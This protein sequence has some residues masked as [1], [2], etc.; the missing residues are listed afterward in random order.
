MILNSICSKCFQ[1]VSEVEKHVLV[2]SFLTRVSTHHRSDI[3]HLCT[4]NCDIAKFLQTDGLS[5]ETFAIAFRVF[6]INT[7]ARNLEVILL[8]VYTVRFSL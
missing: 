7:L 1:K 2:F 6:P 3:C 8:C 5:G 4:M